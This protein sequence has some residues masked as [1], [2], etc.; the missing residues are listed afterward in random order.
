MIRLVKSMHVISGAIL[1]LMA[2]FVVIDVL[3]RWLLR[4]P[5]MGSYD[6]V[7]M[8]GGLVIVLAIPYATVNRQ[9]VRMEFFVSSMA[10]IKRLV[11]YVFTR[12]LGI[13]LFI[14]I[15]WTLLLK[16]IDFYQH[17]EVSPTL[18]LWLYPATFAASFCCF[19]QCLVQ[20]TDEI[21]RAVRSPKNE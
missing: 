19:V 4:M 11:V 18:Q 8:C 5:I 17:G 6:I 12:V 10:P 14:I 13:V 20:I 2:F 3:M 1:F 7:E 21:A 9:H 16:G 15:A